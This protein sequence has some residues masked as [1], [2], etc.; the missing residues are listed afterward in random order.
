[1]ISG[2]VQKISD[3]L[4]NCSAIMVFRRKTHHV[5]RLVY[6]E[7]QHSA[8]EKTASDEVYLGTWTQTRFSSVNKLSWLS[9]EMHHNNVKKRYNQDCEW[10]EPYHY[11][12]S[13][14]SQAMR[15]VTL[16]LLFC[17]ANKRHF[18]ISCIIRKRDNATISPILPTLNPTA[19]CRRPENSMT[20]F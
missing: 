19:N 3:F 18:N 16:I 13:R 9:D 15:I 4:Q 14:L 20:V 2:K 10:L 11:D 5:D 7:H 12:L 6:R 17:T 8:S 1:M